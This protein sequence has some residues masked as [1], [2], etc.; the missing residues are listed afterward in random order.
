[1]PVTEEECDVVASEDSHLAARI[2]TVQEHVRLENLHDLDGIMHTYGAVARYHDEPWGDHRISRE[3]VRQY[4]EELLS[5]VTALL[6]EPQQQY[7][8]NEAII[9]EAVVS[10]MHTGPWRGLPG[11]GRR[12]QFTLCAIYT[13][14]EADKLEAETIYYDRATVLAQLGLFHE[15]STLLGR[16][17]ISLSHPLTSARVLCRQILKR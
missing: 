11:T 14:D 7:A 1:M 13:F 10:G 17:R 8:T 5:A 3:A 12:I 4:Y 16:A 2:R 6:I 9:L 15:P